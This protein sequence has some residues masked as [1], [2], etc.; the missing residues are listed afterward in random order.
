MKSDLEAAFSDVMT[1]ETVQMPLMGAASG[2]AADREPTPEELRQTYAEVLERFERGEVTVTNRRAGGQT[3]T[4]SVGQPTA[5]RDSQGG[6]GSKSPGKRASG[7]TGGAGAAAASAAEQR[8][9]VGSLPPVRGGATVNSAAHAAA[10]G[11]GA[12]PAPTGRPVPS[13]AGVAISGAE[14]EQL[15]ER[16]FARLT[17]QVGNQV[18]DVVRDELRAA[19]AGGG[20]LPDE[21]PAWLHRVAWV[22]SPRWAVAPGAMVVAGGAVVVLVVASWFISAAMAGAHARRAQAAWLR[23][24]LPEY[25][26]VLAEPVGRQWVW[27]LAHNPASSIEQIE[28]CAAAAGL[29]RAGSVCTGRGGRVGWRPAP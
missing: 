3:R 20:A 10:L 24:R 19:R 4:N 21:A 15:V 6:G 5:A 26:R 11:G 8:S 16:Q 13:G 12:P 2:G 9:R 1:A 18:R 28:R 7:G 17:E 23:T 27:M 29:R 25:R 14:A 22:V